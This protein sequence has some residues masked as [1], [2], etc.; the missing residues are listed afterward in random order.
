MRI[1]VLKKKWWLFIF[2]VFGIIVGLRLG[3]LDNLKDIRFYKSATKFLLSSHY[4]K[5]AIVTYKSGHGKKSYTTYKFR[6]EDGNKYYT[7]FA[8]TG[9]RPPKVGE[10]VV[11]VTM[12]P[13][14]LCLVEG[15]EKTM[16]NA[17]LF[18]R[19]AYVTFGVLLVIASVLVL[20][21][22][23]HELIFGKELGK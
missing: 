13:L 14:E 7:Y 1:E 4:K 2:S 17:Y 9:K 3:I 19:Y 10:N 16:V 6:A 21:N 18:V 15:Q 22:L 12:D 23:F 20:V 8:I 5:N 11:I